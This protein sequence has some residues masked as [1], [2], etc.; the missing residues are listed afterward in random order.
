MDDET[1]K[2]LAWLIGGIAIGFTAW[3]LTQLLGVSLAV[4]LMYILYC[5][6]VIFLIGT[7]YFIYKI[8]RNDLFW[9][10]EHR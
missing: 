10:R 4:A 1:K 7:I 3:A 9:R 8:I 2:K 6:P 5:L